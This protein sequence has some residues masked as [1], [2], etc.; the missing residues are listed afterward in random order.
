MG[1][2][3]YSWDGIDEPSAWEANMLCNAAS[4]IKCSHLALE[5]AFPLIMYI[6]AF[7]AYITFKSCCRPGAIITYPIEPRKL[8]S[9]CSTPIIRIQ[10]RKLL[11]CGLASVIIIACQQSGWSNVKIGTIPCFFAQFYNKCSTE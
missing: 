1:W 9:V 10:L 8:F 6:I 4:T 5:N 3:S 7:G 2:T 11:S